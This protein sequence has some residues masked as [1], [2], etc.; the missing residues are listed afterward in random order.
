VEQEF[1]VKVIQEV[2]FQEIQVLEVVVAELVLLVKM[3]K[4]LLFQVVME[5]PMVVMVLI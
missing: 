3:D 2:K 5:K 4:V 1:V